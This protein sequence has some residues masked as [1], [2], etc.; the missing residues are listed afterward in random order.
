VAVPSDL[1]GVGTDIGI[2]TP[3][4]A[5]DSD[6][7]TDTDPDSIARC[8]RVTLAARWV[9]YAKPPFAGPDSV[10]DYL[11]RYTHRIAISNER[12]L[13]VDHD[14]VR[15]RYKD[16][17]HGNA[18]NVL[19]LSATEF[20]RRFLLHVVPRGFMRVRH[21]G[22]LANCRRTER[23]ARCRELLASVPPP[24]PPPAESLAEAVQR[25]MS[26]DITRCPQCGEAAMRIVEDLSPQRDD[27]S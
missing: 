10:L 22:L 21:Y 15:F 18:V 23:L 3:A 16:Y 27:T 20:L 19:E 17:A 9:V 12:L 25:L 24:P 7:D 5:L 4:V 26:I 1:F 8:R 6:T 11:S 13:T 2:D 14:T